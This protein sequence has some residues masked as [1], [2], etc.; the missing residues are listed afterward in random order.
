MAAAL[1]CVGLPMP[2]EICNL[3]VRNAFNRISLNE[4][5]YPCP[6]DEFFMIEAAFYHFN[7][8]DHQV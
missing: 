2:K 4:R 6:D 3:P 8:L 1:K 7:M 5:K